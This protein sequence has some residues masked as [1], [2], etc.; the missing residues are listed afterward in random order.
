MSLYGG[1]KVAVR[2]MVRSWIQDIKGSG[3]RSTF[4]VQAVGLME[5]GDPMMTI[6]PP[7]GSSG[8]AG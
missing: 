6:V 4:L 7:L 2:C 5:A 1:S 3:V 8:K